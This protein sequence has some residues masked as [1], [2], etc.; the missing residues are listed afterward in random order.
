MSSS[1]KPPKLGYLDWGRSLTMF[2]IAWLIGVYVY[3]VTEDDYGQGVGIGLAILTLVVN[4]F[5]RWR[6]VKGVGQT[7]FTFYFWMAVPLILFFIVPCAVKLASYFGAEEREPWWRYMVSLLPFILKLGVPVAA[8]F[9]V[10]VMLGRIR[11]RLERDAAN[12]EAAG[13]DAAAGGAAATESDQQ[14]VS[15]ETPPGR[16]PTE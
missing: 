7:T 10:Y 12:A 6:A 16:Q 15:A 1:A 13:A 9:W 3:D 8:L 2:I 14:A 4:G 5:A 11:R